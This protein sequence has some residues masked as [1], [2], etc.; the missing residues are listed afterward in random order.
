MLQFRTKM[1]SMLRK[2]LVP[3]L[4][5]THH[6][7]DTFWGPIWHRFPHPHR[8]D[9]EPNVRNI[10]RS[11]VRHRLQAYLFGVHYKLV[12]LTSMNCPLD[13]LGT[14]RLNRRW[15]CFV[16]MTL[17]MPNHCHTYKKKKKQIVSNNFKIELFDEMFSWSDDEL[18]ISSSPNHDRWLPVIPSAYFGMGNIRGTPSG[19]S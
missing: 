7:W 10:A 14:Q 11:G 18:G 3:I 15:S 16:W 13:Q 8:G 5:G 19:G 6:Y 2:W 9:F 4:V 1:A 17:R 12:D